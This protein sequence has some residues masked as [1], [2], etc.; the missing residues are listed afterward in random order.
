MLLLELT[1]QVKAGFALPIF[2]SHVED[3]DS[4]NQEL[5]EFLLKER[6][7]AKAEELFDWRTMSSIRSNPS[8]ESVVTMFGSAINHLTRLQVNM[9]VPPSDIHVSAD[10]WGTVTRGGAIKSM[11]N[12]AP[13]H[14]RGIYFLRCDTRITIELAAP[15]L[16][17]LLHGTGKYGR[18]VCKIVLEPTASTAIV[19]PAQLTHSILYGPGDGLNIALEVT[20]GVL[21]TE[22]EAAT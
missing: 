19:F 1:K 14:W 8:V 4:L 17:V 2:Q 13:L 10:V 15:Y 5:S 11:L 3:M 7:G 12:Y 16:P 6:I 20:G 22:K 18:Q 21:L 9:E